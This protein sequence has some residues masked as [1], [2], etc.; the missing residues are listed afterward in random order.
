MFHVCK[1]FPVA[2]KLA[3]EIYECVDV[4]DL[5]SLDVYMWAQVL[6]SFAFGELNSFVC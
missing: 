3:S 2:L 5:L 4:F 6:G 1:I